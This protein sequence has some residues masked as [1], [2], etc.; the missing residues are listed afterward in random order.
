RRA[1]HWMLMSQPHDIPEHL[2]TAA[3]PPGLLEQFL[4]H[5][6]HAS[7]FSPEAY[8]E[9]PPC[10]TPEAI[11][12]SCAASRALP[13]LHAQHRQRDCAAGRQL[14]CPTLVLYGEKTYGPTDMT[15]IWGQYVE[16]PQCVMVPDTGHY[17]AE[18]NP[19]ATLD[20]LLGFFSQAGRR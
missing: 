17:L 20:A 19:Q 7:A 4:R 16:A 9:Y 8:S 12:L 6:G 1:W 5:R 10:L 18:E 15:T 13:T 3:S 14:S 11:A 2:L